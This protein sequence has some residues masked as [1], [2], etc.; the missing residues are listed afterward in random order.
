[1]SVYI[2]GMG[3]LRSGKNAKAMEVFTFNRQQHPEEKFWTYL[4]RYT[5][6]GCFAPTGTGVSQLCRSGFSPRTMA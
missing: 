1:M 4:P 3:L 2:L 6:T 5:V